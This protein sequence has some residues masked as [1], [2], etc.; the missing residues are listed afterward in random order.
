MQ[1]W[2]EK[3]PTGL[4]L[5][6]S[7]FEIYG[8]RCQDLLNNRHRLVVREDGRGD[9]VITGLEECEAQTEEDLLAAIERVSQWPER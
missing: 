7:F 2:K 9:V 4:S 1:P 8:G 5:Y 3:A 6:V